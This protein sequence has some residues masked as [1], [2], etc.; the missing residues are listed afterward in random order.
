MK[1]LSFEE[2][3]KV[4]SMLSHPDRPLQRIQG[5]QFPGFFVGRRQREQELTSTTAMERVLVFIA[6]CG[7]A[8][9]L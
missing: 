1:R 3:K 7:R 6:R 2:K 4:A 8:I 9:G 5:K